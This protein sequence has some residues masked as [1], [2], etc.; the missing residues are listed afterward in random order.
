[1]NLSVLT[2]GFHAWP[3]WNVTWVTAV[4]S[5]PST[6]PYNYG[7]LLS[8]SPPCIGLRRKVDRSNRR[9]VQSQWIELA[10]PVQQGTGS[11][12]TSSSK[13]EASSYSSD[14]GETNLNL[15]LFFFVIGQLEWVCDEFFQ[16]MA[17][18]KW[19]IL[20]QIVRCWTPLMDDMILWFIFGLYRKM[21]NSISF[22]LVETIQAITLSEP[23]LVLTRL[24]AYGN[25]CIGFASS[26]LNVPSSEW[27]NSSGLCS[28]ITM[29]WPIAPTSTILKRRFVAEF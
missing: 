14:S 3:Q 12:R 2:L 23:V 28:H 13:L 5:S 1:M 25:S 21:K 17:L 6:Y 8:A 9:D 27:H 16:L 20:S 10:L 22:S 19:F 26:N 4:S 15:C 29:T 11:L 18:W 24:A 7:L